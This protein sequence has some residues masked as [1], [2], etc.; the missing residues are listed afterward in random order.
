MPKQFMI[1][2][3]LEVLLNVLW[4]KFRQLSPLPNNSV[5]KANH[6]YLVKGRQGGTNHQQVLLY[7]GV[8]NIFCMPGA[9]KSYMWGL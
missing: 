4:P 7:V 5:S 3:G 1:Q 8:F 9:E 2:K 6:P